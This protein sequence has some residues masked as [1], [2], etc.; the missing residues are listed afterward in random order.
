MKARSI[1]KTTFLIASL[2]V[3]YSAMIVIEIGRGNA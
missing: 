1:A 3:M 2:I